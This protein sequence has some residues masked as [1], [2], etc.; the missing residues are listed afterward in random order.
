MLNYLQ[1][2]YKTWKEKSFENCL[3]IVLESPGIKGY[4]N[5]MLTV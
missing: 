2:W 3:N 4:Y 5:F 1:D